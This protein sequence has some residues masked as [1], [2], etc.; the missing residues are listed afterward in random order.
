MPVVLRSD[1]QRVASVGFTASTRRVLGTYS[2][3]V[4]L[5]AFSLA[6]LTNSV[7][8]I[9]LCFVPMKIGKAF[10]DLARLAIFPNC[11]FHFKLYLIG[12]IFQRKDQES[13]RIP[14]LTNFFI[15]H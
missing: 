15:Q 6:S 12:L 11:T 4:S 14:F 2:F 3:L 5:V 10:L 13:K 1:I 9:V 8:P 7:M